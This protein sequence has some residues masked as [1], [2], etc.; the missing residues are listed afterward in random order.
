MS[1]IKIGWAKRDV[2]TKEPVLIQGQTY[3]RVNE[4]IHDPLYSTALCFENDGNTVVFCT[5]DLG[6][7]QPHLTEE[8]YDFVEKECPELSRKDIIIG[9]THTHASLR[10]AP[11]PETT[12]DGVPLYD[13]VKARREYAEKTA[14][15]IVEAYR[16]RKE[17]AVAYGYGYAVVGHSRRSRYF[18]DK[19]ANRPDAVA[20]NGYAV[21]YGKT[22][23]PDFSGYEAG[24]DHFINTMFTFDADNKLTG[25]IV[26]V[27]CPSQISEHFT[28]LS[29]D[30]WCEVKEGIA[31]EFGDEVFVLPQ[32]AAAGDLA[33]RILHYK[34]AQWRRF[35]LKYGIKGTAEDFESAKNFER[36]MCERRD[37]AERIVNSVKEIYSWA[38]SDIRSEVPVKHIRMDTSLTRRNITEKDV[39][40]CKANIKWLEEHPPVKEEMTP[41][42]YRVKASKYKTILEKNNN[43][44]KAYEN[45]KTSPKF[46]AVLHGVRIGEVG[47]ATCQFELYMDYMH[48]IQARSP[49]MQTFVVQ[50]AGDIT[51]SYLPTERAE[52][53]KGYSASIF[54]NRVGHEGGNELV[55]YSLKMLNEMA[56]SKE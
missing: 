40:E 56:D 18:V 10:L 27:P 37:I 48:R 42:E 28:K 36:V 26:N 25:M 20:P 9:V 5:M 22:N 17:G 35:K 41:E 33:P 19:G 44:I 13:G 12:P 14:E 34:K 55:E 39:E 46:D 32:C 23:D 51:G 4:G 21:M 29:A 6:N 38:K 1:K 52:Q 43:G 16:N 24:A 54:C 30:Y 45:L 31:K 53:G 7:I 11:S 50:L 47:F 3:M 15:A 2:S 49:F 8:I